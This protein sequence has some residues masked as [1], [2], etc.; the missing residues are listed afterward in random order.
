[1]P[2]SPRIQVLAVCRFPN[3]PARLVLLP[4]GVEVIERT[5][6]Q[7]FRYPALLAPLLFLFPPGNYHLGLALLFRFRLSLLFTGGT[8]PRLDLSGTPA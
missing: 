2:E 4:A 7:T 6:Y 5:V 8:L 1:M 3:F